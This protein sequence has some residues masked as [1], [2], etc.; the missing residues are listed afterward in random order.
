MDN[1]SRYE[2]L[3][4]E[5][6]TPQSIYRLGAAEGLDSITLIRMIRKVFGLSLAETKKAVGLGFHGDKGQELRLGGTVEWDV[7]TLDG[8]RTIREGK[9]LGLEGGFVKIEVL[10]EFDLISGE[11]RPAPIQSEIVRLHRSSFDKPLVDRLEETLRFWDSLA[12]KA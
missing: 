9:V 8:Q 12:Q 10:R 11:E 4:Q 7:S 1:F 6:G 2:T 5:G 3:R